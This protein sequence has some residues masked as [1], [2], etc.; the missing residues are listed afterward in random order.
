MIS[1]IV[2]RHWRPEVRD[3]A[4][5]LR[6]AAREMPSETRVLGPRFLGRVQPPG[7]VVLL[8][9]VASGHAGVGAASHPS[10]VFR[11]WWNGAD[12]IAAHLAESVDH[13]ADTHVTFFEDVARD[14]AAQG[15]DVFHVP[16]AF[17]TPQSM[18]APR[19][20]KIGFLG[21][22]EITDDCFEAL[23][24][25]GERTA[26]I[27]AMT[28][29]LAHEVCAGD[30]TL[31][32]AEAEIPRRLGALD[33]AAVRATLWSLRN[34]VRFIL[35]GHVIA[36]FPGRVLLRGD[37]WRG[38][39]LAAR[40]TSRSRLTRTRDYRR[41][42][43]SLDLGSKSTYSALYPRAA[44]ILAVGGGIVQWHSGNVEEGTLSL[45]EHRRA[46]SGDALVAMIENLLVA[47]AGNIAEE[48]RALQNAYEK[49]RLES[50]A[51][52]LRLMH[53]RLEEEAA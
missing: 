26:N 15:L 35:V 10:A 29:D 24:L 11:V 2:G 17:S 47:G 46:S 33:R 21:E 52:L 39:G 34:R 45:I 25:G 19:R 14:G 43:V 40:R 27:S 20:D 6:A 42:R 1:V 28:W 41:N 50:G 18:Q 23:S 48:N 44:D 31:V 9:D 7:D 5:T 53:E 22:V 37:D 51:Q 12:E 38:L 8:S 36:H 13:R 3:I 16:Y 30:L 4:A 32:E 49:K